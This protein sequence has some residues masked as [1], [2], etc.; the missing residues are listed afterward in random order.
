MCSLSQF[1]QTKKSSC[2]R[3]SPTSLSRGLSSEVVNVSYRS[4][5]LHSS[6]QAFLSNH[7]ILLLQLDA[8]IST[9]RPQ[10]NFDLDDCASVPQGGESGSSVLVAN[11]RLAVLHYDQNQI[12]VEGRGP[13]ALE[14]E[15]DVG[16]FGPV[17][18][19]K[20][21]DGHL[22]A[23]VKTIVKAKIDGGA[24]D[25][26][27]EREALL[28]ISRHRNVSELLYFAES[29]DCFFFF[30]EYGGEDLQICYLGIRKGR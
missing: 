2:F 21:A 30:L 10:L 3:L 26:A 8:T 18:L 29:D 5:H 11:A 1:G 28:A 6:H 9:A 22:R 13:M 19:A 25:P 15:I 4:V 17:Y 14:K 27:K 7:N 12:T 24:D 16:M 20:E 23:V